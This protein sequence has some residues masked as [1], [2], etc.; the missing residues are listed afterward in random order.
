MNGSF[1]KGRKTTVSI[2]L[3]LT[4]FNSTSHAAHYWNTGT[5]FISG[6]IA[7][8][9]INSSTNDLVINGAYGD[10]LG[11]LTGY[12]GGVGSADIGSIIN[13]NSDIKFNFGNLL[14]NDTVVADGHKVINAGASLQINNV[15]V[16]EGEYIQSSGA[17]VIFGV[18]NNAIA[19]G[20]ILKDSGVGTLMA[21]KV[22]LAPGSS[23][24][25][26]D[27]GSGYAYAQGQRFA[28]IAAM[29][30][31]NTNFNESS[32][33]YILNATGLRLTGEAVP[34]AGNAG[35]A[36]VLTV[37]GK[38]PNSVSRNP[39]NSEN[40]RVGRASLDGL[41]RYKGMDA[42]LMN[43]GNAGAALGKASNNG[44][45]QLSPAALASSASLASSNSTGR[46]LD[47]VSAHMDNLST[48]QAGDAGLSRI[49]DGK[50]LWSQVYSGNSHQQD[51]DD[52]AGYHAFYQ[53]LLVGGDAALNDNWVAGVLI[54][55]TKTMV[56]I[57]GD[58]QRSC[59]DI[60]SYGLIGYSTY[61][62]NRWYLSLSAGAVQQK[63]EIER[64][65]TLPGFNGTP[66]GGYDGIQYVSAAQ[67]SYPIE[68][69]SQTY[70]TPKAGLL[71]SV[72]KQD[73][74]TEQ[75]GNGAALKVV[76]DDTYSLKSN[77]SVKLEQSYASNYGE[78]IPFAQ[79][80]WR[81]EFRDNGLH[82]VANYAADAS[83]ETRFNANGPSAIKDFGMLSLGV[84]ILRNNQLNLSAE[85]TV[86]AGRGFTS[87]TGNLKVVSEF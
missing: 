43:L 55:N 73:R 86:E 7:G 48:S 27:T 3:T 49:T 4:L 71:Y 13:V 32:L 69:R 11:V 18:P 31:S 33:N 9:V 74:Y 26:S 77:L 80:N 36:L 66:T 44:G 81:H 75:G 72:L 2:F 10:G 38:G 16:I 39:V 30:S 40:T 54:S 84:S 59:A 63:Y 60:D 68:L 64:Q 57:D 83:G 21:F 23:V 8:D 67:F 47:I 20:D 58:Y 85:Y 37:V 53:G 5:Y 76:P 24:G 34:I 70:L 78:F 45:A 46:V 51:R 25:L 62:G 15:I 29:D 1:L 56:R 41:F 19:T 6:T 28:V 22:I 12:S 14:L 52:I 61:T 79:L 82:A 42:Q 65:I 17:A 87:S 35:V 50:G